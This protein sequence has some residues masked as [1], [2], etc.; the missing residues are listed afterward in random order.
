MLLRN[1]SKEP[2]ASPVHLLFGG[3]RHEAD[4]CDVV[5]GQIEAQRR[6]VLCRA[7]SRGGFNEEGVKREARV[8]TGL[9]GK[10]PRNRGDEAAS[11][12]TWLALQIAVACRRRVRAALGE[13]TRR[14]PDT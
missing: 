13:L 6:A 11:M 3:R 12:C 8:W 7:P 10:Q 5:M 2:C 1:K 4:L 14:R 9:G